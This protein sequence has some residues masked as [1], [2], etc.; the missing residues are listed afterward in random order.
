M[1]ELLNKAEFAKRVGISVPT[2]ERRMREGLV[3]HT[4]PTPFRVYFTEAQVEKYLNSC[5][6]TQ[7][8]KRPR[9]KVTRTIRISNTD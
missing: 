1:P 6:T 4:R 8:T 7:A 5:A 2:L 3:E 9:Q